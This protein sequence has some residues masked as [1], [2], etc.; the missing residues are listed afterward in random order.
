VLSPSGGTEGQWILVTRTRHYA[1]E[2]VLAPDAKLEEAALHVISVQGNGPLTRARQLS[3]LALGH[4]RDDPQVMVEVTDRVRIE[5]DK[6]VP[7]EIDGEA[8]GELPL[9]IGIHPQRLAV[10]FPNRT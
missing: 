7:V 9:E 10:I 3:A 5:G 2:F 8:L 1:G 6:S 4:I